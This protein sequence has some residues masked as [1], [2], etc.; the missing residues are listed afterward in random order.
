MTSDSLI[1]G[2]IMREIIQERL[3]GATRNVRVTTRDGFVTLR[4]TVSAEFI[5]RR[6]GVIA[7]G[8]VSWNNVDNRII[9]VSSGSEG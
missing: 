5:S 7:A 3:A 1:T 9:V 8:V 4:G 6:V 2:A